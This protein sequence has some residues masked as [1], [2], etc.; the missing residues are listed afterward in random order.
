MDSNAVADLLKAQGVADTVIAS[1]YSQLKLPAPAP[2][3]AD[4]AGTVDIETVKQMIAK[5][6]TER[7]VRL[8]NYMTKQLKVA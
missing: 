4:Q 6:P 1:V 3:A 5:L 7:K 8:I 2:G